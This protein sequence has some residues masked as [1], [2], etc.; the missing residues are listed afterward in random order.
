MLVASFCFATECSLVFLGLITLCFANP[1]PLAIG[2]HILMGLVYLVILSRRISA[3]QTRFTAGV[4][5][6]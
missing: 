5:N 1:K 3:F 2:L 6:A 4:K